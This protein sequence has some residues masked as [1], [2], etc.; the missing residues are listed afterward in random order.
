MIATWPMVGC[1]GRPRTAAAWRVED[2][3]GG[4]AAKE[5]GSLASVVL[6]PRGEEEEGARARA[7]RGEVCSSGSRCGGD[8]RAGGRADARA[9][10]KANARADA[11]GTG[12]TSYQFFLVCSFFLGV[13]MKELTN[14]V[15]RERNVWSSKSQVSQCTY[16][17]LVSCC[18]NQPQCSFKS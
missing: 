6:H 5:V 10:W 16:Y 1:A 17:A 15:Y 13:E 12:E 11:R 3:G 2:V 9:E 8:G 14:F 18:I 4:W 7:R